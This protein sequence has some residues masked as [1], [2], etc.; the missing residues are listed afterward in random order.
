MPDP[1]VQLASADGTGFNTY[2]LASFTGRNYAK[3]AEGQGWYNA[4]LDAL[5]TLRNAWATTSSSS[6]SFTV[7][8]KVFN[9]AAGGFGFA[10]G[11]PVRVAKSA[12]EVMD[13]TVTAVDFPAQTMTIDVLSVTGSGS[14]ASWSIT[15]MNFV[16]TIVST[17]VSIANGGTAA[18]TA[19][20]AR[21]NFDLF[22]TYKVLS[23]LSTPPGSPADQARHLVGDAPTGAYVGHENEIATFTTGVGWAFITAIEGESAYDV[24]VDR[25]YLYT[26][27]ELF[28]G[29]LW[30]DSKWRH[31]TPQ[32][33]SDVL[34]IGTGV[35]TLVSSQL[36][37]DMIIRAAL[38]GGVG[39]INLPSPSGSGVLGSRILVLLSTT[40]T[41]TVQ[42]TGATTINGS[43]T[44]VISTQYT[45]KEFF[46]AESGGG[47][48]WYM[49]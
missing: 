16:S 29:G 26:D 34:A 25:A 2:T 10:V 27:T 36:T 31:S 14:H 18:T 41:L 24:A 43:L 8:S 23:I 37:P 17:P 11:S 38:D 44:Q 33:T 12:T 4:M 6:H 13:G 30:G 46:A 49:R 32:I 3:T 48:K 9:I 7:G 47:G 19:A 5:Y 45:T 20:G 1:S 35:T 40:G 42:V 22:R 28:T 21:T 39:T 15:Q